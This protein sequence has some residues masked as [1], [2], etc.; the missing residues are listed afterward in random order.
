MI[1]QVDYHPLNKVLEL[2]LV[3]KIRVPLSLFMAFRAPLGCAI[4][5][6]NVKFMFG[7]SFYDLGIIMRE[8]NTLFR[9]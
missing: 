1:T 3:Y 8:E 7:E 4:Q 5:M 6:L 9:I 2:D